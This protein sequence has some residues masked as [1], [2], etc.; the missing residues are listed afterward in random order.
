MAVAGHGPRADALRAALADAVPGVGV[1]AVPGDG[2]RGP[3]DLAGID[4]VLVATTG[5]ERAATVLACL[6]AAVPVLVD[7]PL[8][9]DPDTAAA[10]VEAA[11]RA[12][13]TVGPG[14]LRV[15]FA[16]RHDPRFR[17]L[18]AHLAA[19]AVGE[20]RLVRAVEVREGPGPLGAGEAA[21]ARVLAVALDT[22]AWLLDDSVAAVRCEDHG[23][24]CLLTATTR[25]G[26]T[27]DLEVGDGADGDG[28]VRWEVV[29]SDGS[30]ELLTRA[31]WLAEADRILLVAWARQLGGATPI[32]AGPA[33]G[34]A[35]DRAVAA[36]R[37]SLDAG[38][39]VP[40]V[41]R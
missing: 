40:V 12:E 7:P 30:A 39:G 35:A 4:G 33:D 2:V 17:D 32:A 1:V 31:A 36:A 24:L 41:P 38:T 13:A 11:A 16:R 3:A 10:L 5:S 9:G 23:D 34:L 27:L 8:A 21:G 6:A 26:R 37:A 28:E 22:L 18:R 29:G 20:V 15:G 14:A 25:D 19:G